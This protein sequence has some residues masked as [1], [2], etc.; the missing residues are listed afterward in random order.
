MQAAV[1][2]QD[3]SSAENAILCPKIQSCL[4][5]QDLKNR[6]VAVSTIFTFHLLHLDCIFFHFLF[7]FQNWIIW[8]YLEILILVISLC[9]F[10]LF[11]MNVVSEV[12]IMVIRN[13]ATGKCQKL[14]VKYR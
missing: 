14:Q 6:S 9:Y 8:V 10:S 5:K 11:C 3:V 13:D 1:K 7:V 4:P 12:T 2:L